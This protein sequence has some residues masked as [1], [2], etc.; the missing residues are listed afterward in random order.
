VTLEIGDTTGLGETRGTEITT[1]TPQALVRA[2]LPGVLP[3]HAARLALRLSRC[4]RPGENDFG[5]RDQP[6]GDF[7]LTG[8]D[9]LLAR[10]RRG[11]HDVHQ[12]RLRERQEGVEV[13]DRLYS[14]EAAGLTGVDFVVV[15]SRRK[16]DWTR[17]RLSSPPTSGTSW[18]EWFE[19]R[20]DRGLRTFYPLT[21]LKTA[22]V[23]RAECDTNCRAA[24]GSAG[25][26]QARSAGSLNQDG[27]ER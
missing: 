21:E 16:P 25:C 11:A 6:H 27:P 26:A 9:A 22:E 19:V 3:L 2:L 13:P 18:A 4:E 20:L 10:S 15:S 12:R 14:G 7:I 17:G 1:S 24:A 23:L 8:L 5:R